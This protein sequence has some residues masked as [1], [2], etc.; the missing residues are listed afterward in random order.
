MLTVV[1]RYSLETRSYITKVPHNKAY[2]YWKTLVPPLELQRI[3][4]E[5][6]STIDGDDI[7]T[8]SWIPG[9]D[10][11]DTPYQALYDALQDE[12]LAARF[13]GLVMWEVMLRRPE[14]WSFGRYEKDNMPIEGLTH[15]RFEPI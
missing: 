2:E 11:T 7:H 15:F 1:R 9:N 12:S 13:F 5:F 4:E 10:W 6:N 8:S 14:M 3:F